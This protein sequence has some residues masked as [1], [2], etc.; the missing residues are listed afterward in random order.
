MWGTCR[1]NANWKTDLSR[2]QCHGQQTS[3]LSKK[4]SFLAQPPYGKVDLS[5]KPP[6]SVSPWPP[7]STHNPVF[8]SHRH[9]QEG[10][11]SRKSVPFKHPGSPPSYS[12]KFSRGQLT[13]GLVITATHTPGKMHDK[14]CTGAE[15]LVLVWCPSHQLLQL[16]PPCGPQPAP[17]L[18][19]EVSDYPGNFWQPQ[20]P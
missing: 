20:S 10:V 7:P 15:S 2:I 13:A 6:S 5:Q 17:G 3:Y 18:W 4:Q 12:S 1:K 9:F 14:V 8:P 19:D 11:G 16:L